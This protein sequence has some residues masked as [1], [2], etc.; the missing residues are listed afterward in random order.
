MTIKNF[1]RSLLILVTAVF[2][3]LGVAQADPNQGPGGP[4]LVITN[5]NQN[6]GKYYAEIL[7][8]EGFNEFAVADIGAV[9][10]TTLNSYDVVIL[11]KVA[12]TGTQATMLS[13]WVTAGGN[14]VAMDPAPQ[15]AGLLGITS[16]ATTLSNGYLLINTSTK[17][18]SGIPAT[19]LQFHGTAQLSTLAGAQSLA[20]LYSNATTATG[21]PAVTLRSV[22]ANGG[23]AAAF[24][25]D[26]ATSIV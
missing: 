26:L 14:L 8:T 21:S 6:F 2:A 20:T 4:I 15:L 23:Q 10:S 19:T 3:P 16:G 13:D 1:A 18:G 11:A 17:A 7:R 5:G 25:Y 24:M 22:G 9:T 12:V